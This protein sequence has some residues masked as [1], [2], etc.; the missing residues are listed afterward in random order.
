MER[1]LD[2]DTAL[3]ILSKA[4]GRA[5]NKCEHYL[6]Q[7]DFNEA[8]L[9]FLKEIA[10]V[11]DEYE[12]LDFRKKIESSNTIGFKIQIAFETMEQ[13]KELRKIVEEIFVQEF[14][15]NLENESL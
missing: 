11:F 8:S 6:K 7:N 14:F 5:L 2:R 12:Y 1:S 3:Q 10:I 13:V 9:V 4:Y 15:D